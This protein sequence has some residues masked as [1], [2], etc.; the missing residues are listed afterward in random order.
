MTAEP[1]PTLAPALPRCHCGR[2]ARGPVPATHDAPAHLCRQCVDHC[3]LAA[4]LAGAGR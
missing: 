3:A 1:T 4:H 2:P